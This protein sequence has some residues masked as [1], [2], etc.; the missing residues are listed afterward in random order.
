M[1]DFELAIIFS[2][3][4]RNLVS[5]DYNLRVAECRTAAWNM[6]AYTGMPLK[7]LDKTFLRDVPKDIYEAT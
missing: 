6:M 5:S 3:L 1:P 4:T 7:S 2:G